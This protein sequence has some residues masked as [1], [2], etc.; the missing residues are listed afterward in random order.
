MGAT[1]F[2]EAEASDAEPET[3]WRLWDDPVVPLWV[4]RDGRVPSELEELVNEI[5]EETDGLSWPRAE[6]EAGRRLGALFADYRD[7]ATRGGHSR[8]RRRWR[9]Q[10]R[11]TRQTAR[12]RERAIRNGVAST[13][14]DTEWAV[15]LDAF[16][17]R[18]AYCGEHGPCTVDHIIPM[19][20]GGANTKENV[21]PACAACNGSKGD[22]D[23]VE[24][25][26]GKGFDVAKVFARID[27]CRSALGR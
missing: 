25:L 5:V 27:L 17:E 22:R 2:P 24:W 20:S 13:L 4:V 14:T 11:S 9:K 23:L 6:R 19:A 10:I 1:T 12:H 16:G 26:D 7:E 18:C 3:S 15:T 21:V 8:E